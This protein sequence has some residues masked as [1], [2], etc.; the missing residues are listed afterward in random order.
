MAAIVGVGGFLG[1]GE[2]NVAV[3]MEKI[4]VTRE[5]DG[6][7]LKLTTVETADS[8]KAARNTRPSPNSGLKPAPTNSTVMPTD[9]RRPRPRPV[10]N[11]GSSTTRSRVG[12]LWA[13]P[14]ASPFRV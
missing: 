3:P 11:G 2:K 1:M 5:G 9:N 8:L 10:H 4:T 13:A 6:D 12:R 7:D 14:R